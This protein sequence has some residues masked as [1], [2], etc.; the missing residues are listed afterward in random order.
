M[1]RLRLLPFVLLVL[2]VS[3]PALA[4]RASEIQDLKLEKEKLNSEIQKLNRQI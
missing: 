3:G 1:K 4:D 2:L